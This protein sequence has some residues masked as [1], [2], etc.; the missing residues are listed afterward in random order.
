MV[1]KF[2]EQTME[3]FVQNKQLRLQQSLKNN[4]ITIK[5]TPL[6]QNTAQQNLEIINIDLYVSQ[7]LL[8]FIREFFILTTYSHILTRKYKPITEI[9]DLKTTT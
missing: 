8:D 7:K 9:I 6:I 2:I 4:S 1:R 3:Q 5:P